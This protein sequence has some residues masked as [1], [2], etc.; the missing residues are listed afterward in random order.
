MMNNKIC[1]NFKGN[2]ENLNADQEI[3]GFFQETGIEVSSTISPTSSLRSIVNASARRTANWRAI[4]RRSSTLA[5]P[6][7][8]VRPSGRR[9]KLFIELNTVDAAY[10]DPC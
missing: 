7:T 9:G 5:M 8:R 2:F 6:T 4:A 1:L 10:W 3:F